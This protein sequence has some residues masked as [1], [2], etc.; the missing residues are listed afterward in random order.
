MYWYILH[1]TTGEREKGETVGRDHCISRDD[2]MAQA[3]ATLLGALRAE[4][5]P[6]GEEEDFRGMGCIGEGQTKPYYP[7][8]PSS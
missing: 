3:N 4:S 7:L 6:F 8:D 1:A 2:P 5:V